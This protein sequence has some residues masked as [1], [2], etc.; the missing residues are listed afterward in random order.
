MSVSVFSVTELSH[1][2]SSLYQ[3]FGD[4][5]D[6]YQDRQVAKA[7]SQH[8]HEKRHE[9]EIRLDNFRWIWE[10]ISLSNQMESI[11]TYT[12]YGESD[13]ITHNKIDVLHQGT[14][15]PN[16]ELH[17]QLTLVRYNSSKF[18]NQDVSQKLDGW[19]EMVADRVI[20]ESDTS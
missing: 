13:S 9:L 20:S 14:A 5:F 1:I 3:N 7:E 11:N 16:K 2:A 12:K 6:N 10:N 17:T 15:I 8:E 18:L 4:F 19:I